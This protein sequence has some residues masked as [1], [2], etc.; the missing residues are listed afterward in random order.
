MGFKLGR[1]TGPTVSSRPHV[2]VCP[3]FYNPKI[4][5]HTKSHK[6]A[7]CNYLCYILSCLCPK[8]EKMVSSFHVLKGNKL[9]HLIDP[10]WNTCLFVNQ[11]LAKGID[12]PGAEDGVC[13]QEPPGL[14]WKS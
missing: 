4:R 10:N 14:C 1:I 2:H 6:T 12:Y 9:S 13:Y 3:K 5:L 11:L 7:T 8:G